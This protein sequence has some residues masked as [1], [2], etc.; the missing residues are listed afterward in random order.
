MFPA[1]VCLKSGL[2]TFL[3][4]KINVSWVISKL[5]SSPLSLITIC[6]LPRRDPFGKTKE[7]THGGLAQLRN[8]FEYPVPF[9]P[10]IFTYPD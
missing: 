1:I 6:S 8:A 10:L 2:N 4:F 3:V 9:Y 5:S 7:I